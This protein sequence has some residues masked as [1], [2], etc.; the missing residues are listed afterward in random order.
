MYYSQFQQG[1]LNGI[2][3][4]IISNPPSIV[5]VKKFS[6]TSHEGLSIY[7]SLN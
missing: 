5:T 4:A 6:G 1:Q 2:G 7:S 3:K